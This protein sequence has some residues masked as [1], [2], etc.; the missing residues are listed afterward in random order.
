M[1]STPP[2]LPSLLSYLCIYLP[3]FLLHFFSPCPVPLPSTL[4][5]SPCLA[6]LLMTVC[7]AFQTLISFDSQ[8]H[9]PFSHPLI[10]KVFTQGP[11]RSCP[12][13]VLLSYLLDMITQSP[14]RVDI[15]FTKVKW[16]EAGLFSPVRPSTSSC[17]KPGL[18]ALRSVL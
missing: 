7:V 1:V 12:Q 13:Q 5:I 2:N 18:S 3:F 6:S 9:C 11:R 15:C 16:G 10:P 17:S 8:R 4:P 14:S